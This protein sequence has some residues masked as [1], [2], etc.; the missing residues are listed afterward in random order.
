MRARLCSRCGSLDLLQVVL[1]VV[2]RPG[3]TDVPGRDRPIDVPAQ[4]AAERDADGRLRALG[5]DMLEQMG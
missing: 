3:P 5:K 2:A 4:H 1:R